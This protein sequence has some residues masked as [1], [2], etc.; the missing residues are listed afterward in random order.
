VKGAKG[1]VTKGICLAAMTGLVINVP[2]WAHGGG[3]GG[4]G[5]GHMSSAGS[6]HSSGASFHSSGASFHSFGGPSFHSS[7]MSFH[8]SSMGFGGNS[9]HQSSMSHAQLERGFEGQSVHHGGLGSAF[10]SLFGGHTSHAVT[11]PPSSIEK[12]EG[13]ESFARNEH[14]HVFDSAESAKGSLAS[15]NSVK[16]FASAPKTHHFLF[17]GRHS[18]ATTPENLEANG[19]AIAKPSMTTFEGREIPLPTNHGL[20]ESLIANPNLGAPNA[21]SAHQAE[22]NAATAAW[23]AQHTGLLAPAGAA[24]AA[25]AVPGMTRQQEDAQVAASSWAAR[26]SGTIPGVA[27]AGTVLPPARMQPSVNTAISTVPAVN[28][29]SMLQPRIGF[30]PTQLPFAGNYPYGAYNP[31]F[32]NYLN[33][34]NYGYWPNYYGNNCGFTGYNPFGY[35]NN[36]YSSGYGYGGGG[37]F[38]LLASLFGMGGYGAYGGYGGYGYPGNYNYDPGNYP[39]YQ[40]TPNYYNGGGYPG[41]TGYLPNNW[42]T[43]PTLPP[44]YS[45]PQPDMVP[46]NPELGE[47]GTLPAAPTPPAIIPSANA[48]NPA[49]WLAIHH[50]VI[51]TALTQ[52][53]IAKATGATNSAALAALHHGVLTTALVNQA[54]SKE[55][56]TKFP[57]VLNAA[58]NHPLSRGSAPIAQHATANALQAATQHSS[59]AK[60]KQA[61]L[62]AA[63]KARHQ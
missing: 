43:P 48:I 10:S 59:L 27:P 61:A 23:E 29:N 52:S 51:G 2:C 35:G 60:Q 5:G 63:S 1:P 36:P 62:A 41:Y 25:A 39:G 32:N 11:S 4:G 40:N 45:T 37:L 31:N 12:A 55:Q 57:Y 30:S 13:A 42:V 54:L 24:A 34:N 33:Y 53:A 28:P 38:G 18:K 21:V 19:A 20:N 7:G 56:R 6:F 15:P 50:G 9:F 58:L 8:P 49:T 3:S 16:S 47:A 44:A 22:A 46:T 14:V 17:F 26:H